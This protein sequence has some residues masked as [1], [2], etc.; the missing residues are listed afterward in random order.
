MVKS[1]LRGEASRASITA[2]PCLPVAPVTRM[3]WAISS[4]SVEACLCVTSGFELNGG[5]ETTEFFCGLYSKE[6]VK[7]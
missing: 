2:P 6:Y 3:E 5:I 7:I 1:L 4:P